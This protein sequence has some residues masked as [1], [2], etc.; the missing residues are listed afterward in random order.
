MASSTG[1]MKTSFR[2]ALPVD[3]RHYHCPTRAKTRNV[4]Q[5]RHHSQIT[6]VLYIT[7]E[8]NILVDDETKLPIGVI[9]TRNDKQYAMGVCKK[10]GLYSIDEEFTIDVT[11]VIT[12]TMW[13][14]Y[15][16]VGWTAGEI[17]ELLVWRK[18]LIDKPQRIYMQ[19]VEQ[20]EKS[21][22]M[23]FCFWPGK[24][25]DLVELEMQ[26]M[27]NVMEQDDLICGNMRKRI[28]KLYGLQ[29]IDELKNM[30]KEQYEK[31]KFSLNETE[32]QFITTQ[33][34]FGKQIQQIYKN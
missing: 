30:V 22:W 19:L 10:I 29:S 15:Q 28:P 27:T 16:R 14:P 5:D 4:F 17:E 11:Q 34:W 6:S 23:L 9:F 26:L 24:I 25:S 2:K 3:I 18:R 21:R 1:T 8:T 7:D 33:A 13:G 12:F 20:F 31:T 32:V